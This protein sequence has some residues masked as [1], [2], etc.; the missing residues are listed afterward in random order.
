MKS[1]KML[2]AFNHYVW[3]RI[4]RI[5]RHLWIM[6]I[7]MSQK[8]TNYSERMYAFTILAIYTPKRIL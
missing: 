8:T 6:N 2:P 7:I 1:M 4:R 5:Y 3:G